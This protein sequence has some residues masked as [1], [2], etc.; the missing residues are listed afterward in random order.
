MDEMGPIGP[1]KPSGLFIKNLLSELFL[2][3]QALLSVRSSGAVAELFPGEAKTFELGESYLT[4]ERSDWHLHIEFS[5]IVSI[6]FKMDRSPKGRLVRAVVFEDELGAPV[7]RGAL[8]TGYPPGVSDP[9]EI[10]EDF[11]SWAKGFSGIS[12]VV[13]DLFDP[14]SG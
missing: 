6:R 11:R 14:V 7:V 13:L 1:E 2:E 3:K 12:F 10:M 8:R 5:R 9:G 4:I